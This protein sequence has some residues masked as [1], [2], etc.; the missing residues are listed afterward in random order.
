[1]G[2][3]TDKIKADN[4]FH[5]AL[6]SCMNCGMCT[7]I[8]PAAEFYK[9]DPRNICNIVHR[10][11]DEELE[12]LLRSD[13]IWYCGQCMSCKTRCPRGN[14]PGVVISILRTISQEMGF[15]TDSEKG[16]QQ[17]AIE[18]II[19]TNILQR[20]YCVHPDIVDPD[21]HPEQGPI[22]AWFMKNAEAVCEKVGAN[23]KKEGPGALRNIHQSNLDEIKNIFDVTGGT[24]LR[25]QIEQFSA[26]K[27]EDLHINIEKTDENQ[28]YSDYLVANFTQNNNQHCK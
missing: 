6:S 23:W 27:A 24:A 15:F 21:L 19:G 10:G 22:W 26:K 11:D 8:C 5:E 20:G 16:R 28:K 3:L 12:K 17:Y 2:I 7:A 4:R 14:A 13:T 1:M 25:E 18:Q 9:Y